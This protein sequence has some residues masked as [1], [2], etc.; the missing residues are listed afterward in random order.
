VHVV[1]IHTYTLGHHHK[2][3]DFLHLADVIRRFLIPCDNSTA[4]WAYALALCDIRPTLPQ[5]RQML[6][7]DQIPV[8]MVFVKEEFKIAQFKCSRQPAN[9][10]EL[11][12][13]I[14]HIDP[15]GIGYKGVRTKVPIGDLEQHFRKYTSPYNMFLV[16]K[17][18]SGLGEMPEM[19]A[20]ARAA[21]QP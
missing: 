18:W 20:A 3:L 19:I 2:V 10:N 13:T 9:L 8:A 12:W 4:H 15:V 21:G 17:M 6:G 11:G 14:C 5:I 7:A 1:L 16:P